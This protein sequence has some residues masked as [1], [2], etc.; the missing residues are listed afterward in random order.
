MRPSVE[1]MSK[2]S[3]GLNY[4][5]TLGGNSPAYMDGHGRRYSMLSISPQKDLSIDPSKA[6]YG[7][8]SRGISAEVG[9]HKIY[10]KRK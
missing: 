1:Y 9:S 6:I 5:Y 7:K 8:K 10:L 2:T 4:S 3:A